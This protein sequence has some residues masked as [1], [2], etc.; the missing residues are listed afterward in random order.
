[1]QYNMKI[2]ELL[3]SDKKADCCANV[4]V[5]LGKNKIKK[6]MSLGKKIANF[7]LKLEV[8]FLELYQ[9]H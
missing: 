4:P 1:M 5:T 8:V 7:H 2:E 9:K 3:T 6:I